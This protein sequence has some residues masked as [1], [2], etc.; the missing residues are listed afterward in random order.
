VS[1]RLKIS[2][3]T[4]AGNKAYRTDPTVNPTLVTSPFRALPPLLT[5]KD[6]EVTKNIKVFLKKSS[7]T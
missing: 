2:A 1:V 4:A 5:N 6:I 3:V 7:S